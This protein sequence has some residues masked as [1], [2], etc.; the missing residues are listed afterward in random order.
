MAFELSKKLTRVEE[1]WLE[2]DLRV[3]L[4]NEE[5]INDNIGGTRPRDG[6]VA[7][8]LGVSQSGRHSRSCNIGN[9]QFKRLDCDKLA[10]T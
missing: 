5:R 9:Q 6:I 3:K 8:C 1:R 7:A 10:V 2:T 4:T